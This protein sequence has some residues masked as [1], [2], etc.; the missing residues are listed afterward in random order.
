MKMPL[1]SSQIIAVVAIAIALAA[2]AYALGRT[3]NPAPLPVVETAHPV[4]EKSHRPP[5][6]VAAN[7]SNSSNSNSNYASN[8]AAP[9]RLCDECFRVVGVRS[10]ERKGQGS[11]LGAVGGALIGGLLGNQV[12][13][14]NGKKL[15]TV[16]GAVAGG[17]AGNEIERRNKSERVWFIQMVNRDGSSQ[18]HQ[19][20]HDPEVRDGD[21]VVLR[22][23]QIQRR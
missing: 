9:A 10:E 22:D 11:G 20:S 15:A 3:N 16:G 1:S 17:M 8:S 23:G 12:G 19:Q 6:R 18:S 14:G 21:V 2:G 4:A 7:N 5:V 13:G